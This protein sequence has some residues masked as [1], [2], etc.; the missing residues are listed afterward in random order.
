MFSKM[1]FSKTKDSVINYL[2]SNF[3][4]VLAVVLLIIILVLVIVY[5]TNDNFANIVNK[6]FMPGSSG[7]LKELGIIMFMSPD[8]PYCQKMMTTLGSNVDD[9]EVV[10]VRSEE[11]TAMA[12]RYGADKL[13]TFISK[14]YKTSSVGL[15]DTVQELINDLKAPEKTE[16][17]ELSNLGICMFKRD[18]CGYCK[19]AKTE[20]EQ[21]GF[22]KYMEVYDL[23]TPEGVKALREIGLSA[24]KGVPLF[25]SR[26]T[27]K[28]SLGYK[29]FEELVMELK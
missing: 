4:L 3:L 9:I 14:K 7:S 23:E 10:D 20:Y 21:N 15:K 27:K 22:I 2:S 5:K 18:S 12:Q 24:D 1:D 6:A 28:S 11:G 19:K 16:E 25:Y 8:C 17:S 13:P 29:P 26:K